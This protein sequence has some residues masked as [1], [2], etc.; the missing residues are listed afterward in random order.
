MQVERKKKH[1]LEVEAQQKFE[2]EKVFDASFIYIANIGRAKNASGA[3]VAQN[4]YTKTINLHL[5]NYIE[6]SRYVV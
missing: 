6:Q 4:V 5:Q 1:D 2:K 3:H